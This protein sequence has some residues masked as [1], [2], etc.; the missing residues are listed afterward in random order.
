MD[1]GRYVLQRISTRCFERA[2]AAEEKAAHH[3]LFSSLIIPM[4]MRRTGSSGG[5]AVRPHRATA[6]PTRS[7]LFILHSLLFTLH[8]LFFLIVK[9]P[10]VPDAVAPSVAVRFT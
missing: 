5:Q 8:C 4:K 6:A 2:N 9:L 7:L 3:E 10:L 1:R